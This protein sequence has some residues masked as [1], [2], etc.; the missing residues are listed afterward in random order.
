MLHI[1]DT[2]THHA[3]FSRLKP[4]S[5]IAKGT[6]ARKFRYPLKIRAALVAMMTALADLRIH[7]SAILE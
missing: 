6:K 3:A 2:E 1:A 4:E 7:R 5:C